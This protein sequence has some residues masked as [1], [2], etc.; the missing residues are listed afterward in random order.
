MLGCTGKSQQVRPSSDFHSTENLW[1][2]CLL[3]SSFGSSRWKGGQLFSLNTWDTAL[4]DP[5]T[6]NM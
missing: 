3:N 4:G 5:G 2:V 6:W 1:V